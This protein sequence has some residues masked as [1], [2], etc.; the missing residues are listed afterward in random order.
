MSYKD[1]YLPIEEWRQFAMYFMI[2]KHRS[3]SLILQS[4]QFDVVGLTYFRKPRMMQGNFWWTTWSY[5]T[6]RTEIRLEAVDKYFAEGWLLSSA[7]RV[8]V[9][10]PQFY[11]AVLLPERCYRYCYAPSHEKSLVNLTSDADSS[12]IT[13]YQQLRD[14]MDVVP[15]FDTWVEHCGPLPRAVYNSLFQ[16]GVPN[17]EYAA[18]STGNRGVAHDFQCRGFDL[19]TRRLH[20]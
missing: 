5:L 20:P 4:Q 17:R 7:G 3:M 1:A 13:V 15:S 18:T 8:R 10:Q 12:V 16:L 11:D 9:Y 19:S 2:G 14:S 6:A